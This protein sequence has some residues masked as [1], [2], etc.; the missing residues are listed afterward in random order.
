[1]KFRLIPKIIVM[2]VIFFVSTCFG[3]DNIQIQ[4]SHLF[5]YDLRQSLHRFY[6]DRLS[7]RILY[8]KCNKS[9]FEIKPFFE[10]KINLERENIERKSFG[11]EI[12][13]EIFSW[14]YLGGI[15]QRNSA[16]EDLFAYAEYKKR[17]YTDFTFKLLLSKYLL[18]KKHLKLKGFIQEEYTYDFDLEKGSRNEVAIGLI[19]PIAKFS[20][21]IVNWRHIDRIHYYDSDTFETAINFTF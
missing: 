12:G 10:T 8:F 21:F 11:L 17:D 5:H 9:L 20:E 15:L 2:I 1:M 3:K 14:L 6:L 19:I 18:D 16:K 13:K 4:W 7:L